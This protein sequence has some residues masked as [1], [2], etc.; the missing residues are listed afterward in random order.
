[1]TGFYF[2]SSLRRVSRARLISYPYSPAEEIQ[3]MQLTPPLRVYLEKG[4]VCENP[5]EDDSC[6]GSASR[7]PA[8]DDSACRCL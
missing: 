2:F 6:G 7:V 3:G 4:D 5:I 1:M 8:V